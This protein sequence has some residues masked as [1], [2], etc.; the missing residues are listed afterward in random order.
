VSRPAGGAVALAF[1]LFVAGA[2]TVQKYAGT[3]GLLAYLAGLGVAT[4]FGAPWVPRLRKRLAD[5]LAIAL[6]VAVL[7]A[8]LGAFAVAYPRANSQSGD[9]GTDRD[10][11]ADIGARHLLDG[12]YPYDDRTYLDQ[13]VSQLPGAL[14]LSAPFVALG[15]SA[16]A[17]F[18]WLPVL[19]LLL[20]A[21][22]RE[23]RTPLLLLLLAL[24]AAP[25][26]LRELLTGGD[27]LANGIYVL[28]ACW[29]VL[30][31]RRPLPFALA[32]LALGF[33][34]SSRL[35]FAFVLPA[36]LATA[37][38]LRGPRQA[39]S[40][41]AL[42]ALAWAATTVPFAL[43]EGRF[44]PFES[45]N[46]LQRFDGVVPGGGTTV[47]VATALA[48]VAAALVPQR[49]SE[50]RFLWHAAATQLALVLSVVVLESVRNVTL[51][52]SP[53]VPGYGLLALFFGLAAA[54]PARWSNP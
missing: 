42:A 39:L 7:A 47:A 8:L 46:Q 16:Y 17:A 52:F 51:D 50:T 32:S 40:G 9:S 15:K 19:F 38:Q 28:V 11:A 25:G 27:L 54:R 43:H 33:A 22:F 23:W 48:A 53:L 1:V 14:I 2:A 35:S 31:S 3:G 36:L 37:I 20:R 10:D 13:A 49:W 44:W 12:G 18:F 34:L 29:L 4:W 26:L 30:R 24:C 6:S 21:R 41:A 5:G 45:S